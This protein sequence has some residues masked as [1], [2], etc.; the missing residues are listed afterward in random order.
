MSKSYMQEVVERY[1]AIRIQ[2]HILPY[3]RKYIIWGDCLDCE[4]VLKLEEGIED[5]KQYF[6]RNNYYMEEVAHVEGK[7]KTLIV[8]NDKIKRW[9][10]IDT[11]V[12]NMLKDK[13]KFSNFLVLFS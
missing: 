2:I 10:T 13:R 4:D 9:N 3:G 8:Y 5:V 1:G 11:R 7:G 6:D 12:Y